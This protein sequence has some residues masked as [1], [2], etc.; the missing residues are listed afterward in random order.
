MSKAETKRFDD[1]W[2]GSQNK[3]LGLDGKVKYTR[4]LGY[5]C[6]DT[7][8]FEGSLNERHLYRTRESYYMTSVEVLEDKS[9]EDNTPILKKTLKQLEKE[10]NTGR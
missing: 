2:S 7:T 6:D 1:I 3:I 9:E 5:N 8:Y 10:P 4:G